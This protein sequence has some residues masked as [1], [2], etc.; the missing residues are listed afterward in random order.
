MSEVPLYAPPAP[1]LP[2]PLP[3][4]WTV[5]IK[6]R[7]FNQ[8]PAGP[9]PLNHRDDFSG[10]AL[11]HESLNSLCVQYLPGRPRAFGPKALNP[12]GCLAHNKLPPPYDPTFFNL[13]YK[14][15]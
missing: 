3:R 10:P 7:V 12:Q 1:R 4:G 2:A 11:R 13:I 8:Q 14:H 5:S 9:N 6:E 15:L